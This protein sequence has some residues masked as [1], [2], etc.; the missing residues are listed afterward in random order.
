MF[1]IESISIS[2]RTTHRELKELGV[3]SC[4]AV[5]KSLIS[6][7]NLKNRPHSAMENKDWTLEQWKF[8]WS[9]EL[10]F[11]LFLI[12]GHIRLRRES[13]EVMHHHTKCLLY[14]PARAVELS[15]ICSWSGLCTATVCAPRRRSADSLVILNDQVNPIENI[16]FGGNFFFSCA[17]YY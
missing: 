7:A 6:E 16:S 11:T 3:N 14:K 2:T 1:N 9:D 8:M 17:V 5:R 13:D 4:V 10:R 15:G 12:D